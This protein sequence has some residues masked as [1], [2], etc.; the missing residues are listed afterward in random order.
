MNSHSCLKVNPFLKKHIYMLSQIG[1]FRFIT[2][3][4][5]RWSTETLVTERGGG[6]CSYSL[7]LSV[8]VGGGPSNG[9]T[10]DSKRPMCSEYYFE[11]E[12]PPIKRMPRDHESK[13]RSQY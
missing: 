6:Y 11:P 12:E 2:T 13:S 9:E 5:K 1:F 3:L 4:L 10:E 7:K 8:N